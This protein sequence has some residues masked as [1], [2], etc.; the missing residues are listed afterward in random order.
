[1]NNEEKI[2]GLLGQ[3][4]VKI[5]KI[6]TSLN[7]IEVRLD[8]VETRLDTMRLFDF[9][10]AKAGPFLPCRLYKIHSAIVI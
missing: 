9:C 3:I 6:E 2:V 8:N 4:V 10:P 7:R 5:D 1:M